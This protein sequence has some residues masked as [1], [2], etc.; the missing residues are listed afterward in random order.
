MLSFS[1]SYLDSIKNSHFM[2]T[3]KEGFEGETRPQVKV[4]LWITLIYTFTHLK[5]FHEGYNGLM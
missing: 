1:I 3:L 2:D 4:I 5:H